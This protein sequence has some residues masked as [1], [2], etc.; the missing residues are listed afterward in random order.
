[1]FCAKPAGSRLV[2]EALSGGGALGVLRAKAATV[3]SDS[4]SPANMGTMSRKS[5]MRLPPHGGQIQAQRRVQTHKLIS[6]DIG[7]PD[8]EAG[9][10]QAPGLAGGGRLKQ[11]AIGAE[12]AGE[13]QRAKARQAGAEASG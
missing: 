11:R 10:G 3:V 6:V 1:M 4:S 8:I 9:G 12:S 2:S 5:F 13:H 7:D